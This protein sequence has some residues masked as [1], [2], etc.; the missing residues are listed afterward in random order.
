[1]KTIFLSAAAIAAVAV[2]PA[3]A[4]TAPSPAG[5]GLMAGKS[6]TRAET[7]QKVQQHFAK[8]DTNKDGFVTK[9][10]ADARAKTMVKHV[11]KRVEHRGEAMFERM[12]SNKDGSIS[13]AEFDAA[14][15]A[16][17]GKMRAGAGKR[18]GMRHAG[19]H[20]RLFDTADANN[21]GRV[22]LQEATGAAASHFDQADANRDGTLSGDEMRAAHKAR[23]AEP[24]N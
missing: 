21:D 12:D 13:R 11:E 4:Q 20:G 10:E 14:H 5:H 23:M 3:I 9:A 17:A 24:A 16:M 19:M 18:M 7:I 22:S 6:V 15:Q 2:V 1:M 8:L